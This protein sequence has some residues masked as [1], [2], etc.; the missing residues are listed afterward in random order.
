MCLA[1]LA[2]RVYERLSEPK[3]DLEFVYEFGQHLSALARDDQVGVDRCASG[4][5]CH[6]AAALTKG[7]RCVD[8][9]RVEDRVDRAVRTGSDAYFDTLRH[10]L[11]LRAVPH[12]SA[13]VVTSI[14]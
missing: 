4:H 9:R 6:V 11:G 1:N 7:R 10:S 5:H 13:D 3:A 2:H 8:P 12:Q 14:E